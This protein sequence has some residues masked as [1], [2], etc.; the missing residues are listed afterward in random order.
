VGHLLSNGEARSIV[1]FGGL[2]AWAVIEMMLLNRRDGART[3]PEPAPIKNDIILL[4]S[5]IVVYAII[6]FAHQWLFGVSPIH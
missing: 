4:I 1:L 5:G 3:V 6:L 2:A